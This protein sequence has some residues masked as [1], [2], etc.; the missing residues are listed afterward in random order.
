MKKR[1]VGKPELLPVSVTFEV[2]MPVFCERRFG[3]RP[4]VI[5]MMLAMTSIPSLCAHQP[6]FARPWEEHRLE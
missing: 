1:P 5:P 2:K 3:T 4:R 6:F